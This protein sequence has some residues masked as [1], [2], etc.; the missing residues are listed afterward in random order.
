M[1]NSKELSLEGMK[2]YAVDGLGLDR[3]SV[4]SVVSAYVRLV[5]EA[6]FDDFEPNSSNLVS[7]VASH[8]KGIGRGTE[9]RE[10]FVARAQKWASASTENTNR[11]RKLVDNWR[12]RVSASNP[13]II[14][15]NLDEL[16]ESLAILQ[17]L[18]AEADQ[19]DI[20]LHGNVSDSWLGDVQTRYPEAPHIHH[21]CQSRCLEG[22]GL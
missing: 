7:P 12:T 22:E 10:D 8:Q 14:C 1:S 3:A 15:C 11:L 16:D 5:T 20:G 6:A 19:L 17:A 13:K 9:E 4:D 18:G 2:A 21:S